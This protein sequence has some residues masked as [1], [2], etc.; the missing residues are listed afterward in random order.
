MLAIAAFRHSHD[1]V[2]PLQLAQMT[3]KLPLDPYNNC[4][5]GYRSDG[6]SFTLYSVGPNA[7]DD[8]GRNEERERY[9]ANSNVP[10]G[11]DDLVWNYRR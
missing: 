2:Y 3:E 11:S 5:F 4:S 1:G 7:A 9:R 6:E 10:V 8:N